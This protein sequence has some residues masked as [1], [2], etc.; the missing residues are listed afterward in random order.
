MQSRF[1]SLNRKTTET[2]FWPEVSNP[3]LN[4]KDHSW[5][6]WLLLY[7]LDQWMKLPLH[8]IAVTNLH[9]NHIRLHYTIIA[10]NMIHYYCGGYLSLV[11]QFRCQKI[12]SKLA[13][14]FEVEGSD[15]SLVEGISS[16]VIYKYRTLI[17]KRAN[18]LIKLC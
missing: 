12:Q 17:Y 6:R 5:K 13:I 2:K 3:T 16:N 14:S 1:Y 18:L 4:M 7:C 15:S 9:Y 8:F 10:W 11:T